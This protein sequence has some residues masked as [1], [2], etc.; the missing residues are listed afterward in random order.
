LL[1]ACIHMCQGRE[2]ENE[3]TK[4]KSKKKTKKC[5]MVAITCKN[6]RKAHKFTPCQCRENE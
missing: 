5:H 2:R 1:I 6:R 4:R 3:R